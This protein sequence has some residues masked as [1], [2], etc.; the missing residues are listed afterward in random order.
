MPYFEL[1]SISKEFPGVKA[2]ADVSFSVERREIHALCGE[3]GAGKSTL[4]KILS[5]VHPHGTFSGQIL[6]QGHEVHFHSIRDVERAGISVIY[7]E[8]ELVKELTVG[9]NIFLGE[10]PQRFGIIDWDKLYYRSSKLLQQL[11]VDLNPRTLVRH[12]GIGQQQL[13]E[14]AKALG[15]NIDIL[16]LDEPT[17]ALTEGEVSILMKILRNLKQRG[18]TSLYISHKLHEILS[19]ADRVTVLRDGKII[20]TEDVSKLD[21]P[22][23]VSMM[24]GRDLT[25]FYPKEKHSKGEKV[26]SIRDL[27]L[28][29]PT[30]SSRKIIDNVSFD[31]FQGEIL[32]I[33]GLMGA[34]RTELLLG[35]FGAWPGYRKGKILA[36]EKPIHIALP[37]DAIRHGIGLISEDRKRNGLILDAAVRLNLTLANL[38][39]FSRNGVLQTNEEIRCSREKVAELSIKVK[40]V[41]ESVNKLSGGNQQKVMFGKWLL[42][43]VKVLFLDEPTRGIDVG[44]KYEIYQIMNELVAQ[45]VAIVM[46]SSE[47]S[48]ILGMSD[49]ILVLHE[50]KVTGEFS[51]PDTTQEKIMLAAARHST[52]GDQNPSH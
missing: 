16:L 1:K 20:A 41:D 40:N 12:L 3:N 10:A 31:I 47:L 8:L 45:G 50:G 2:L 25:K 19:I 32:G 44:A 33:A 11:G 30:E 24:V 14:I 9:E 26:L 42:T 29:D 38:A 22:K 48:E 13:V 37:Q 43:D 51:G 34:G 15:R 4:I 35:I 7:Q 52:I 46:V 5:G 21:E 27:T 36:R 28:Y 39:R 17:A 6:L 49:R 23:L 18:V